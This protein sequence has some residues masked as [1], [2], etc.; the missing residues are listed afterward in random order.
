MQR[1]GPEQGKLAAGN[2]ELIKVDSALHNGL[3]GPGSLH[4]GDDEG[5]AEE[6]QALVGGLDPEG[7]GA[8]EGQHAEPA[9]PVHQLAR[10][11]CC[12]DVGDGLGEEHTPST[13]IQHR[14]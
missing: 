10:P 9:V 12:D 1:K 2:L 6:A 7:C 13:Y 5:G 4:E 8:D 14:S 3:G 11:R